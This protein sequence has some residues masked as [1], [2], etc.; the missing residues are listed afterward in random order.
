MTAGA[1]AGAGHVGRGAAAAACARQPAGALRG[2][3]LQRAVKGG[4]GDNTGWA[5]KATHLQRDGKPFHSF[6]ATT[7]RDVHAGSLDTA[8]STRALAMG[9]LHFVC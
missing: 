7:V 9:K 3:H 8:V 6:A 1:H 4:R 2:A 5:T